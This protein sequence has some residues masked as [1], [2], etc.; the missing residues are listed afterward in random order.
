MPALLPSARALGRPSPHRPHHPES[1]GRRHDARQ[2]PGRA[3]V[4]QPPKV[5]QSA[6]KSMKTPGST[7]PCRGH[8]ASSMS[9]YRLELRRVVELPQRRPRRIGPGVGCRVAAVA[10]APGDAVRAVVAAEERRLLPRPARRVGHPPRRTFRRVGARKALEA[11]Y[12]G[13]DVG[14]ELVRGRDARV[15]GARRLRVSERVAG[16]HVREEHLRR[17]QIP[18]GAGTG[19][20]DSDVVDP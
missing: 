7:R 15:D 6:F 14:R 19:R 10:P 4:V 16:S 13:V 5:R 17:R 2:S 18:D 12:H 1:Q 20:G 3:Q 9:A 8:R 11:R